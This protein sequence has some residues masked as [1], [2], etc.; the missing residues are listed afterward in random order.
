MLIITQRK[1]HN[2]GQLLHINHYIICLNP[3]HATGRSDQPARKHLFV[4]RYTV[5]FQDD[6]VSNLNVLHRRGP[7]LSGLEGL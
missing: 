4:H 5:I 6:D 1:L 2:H 7:L 3:I